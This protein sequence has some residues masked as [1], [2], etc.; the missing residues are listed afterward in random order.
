MQLSATNFRTLDAI[1]A[2]H[3]VHGRYPSSEEVAA[4]SGQSRTVANKGVKS[5]ERH[6]CIDRSVVYVG[7]HH[8][9]VI[10]RV[11]V[12]IELCWIHRPA[13]EESD[14]YLCTGG[15]GKNRRLFSMWWPMRVCFDCMPDA[16][17]AAMA[18]EQD[19]RDEAAE[20][21]WVHLAGR[22]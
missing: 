19:R 15:C 11:R 18:I 22:W 12:P 3:R 8:K 6:R 5:L 14:H 16:P 1:E 17:V 9:S 20:M 7:G 21:S 10:D 4:Q 13:L 2:F